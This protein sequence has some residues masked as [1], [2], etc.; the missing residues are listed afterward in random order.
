[1]ADHGVLFHQEGAVGDQDDAL[2][3]LLAQLV[4][5]DAPTPTAVAAAMPATVAA[6]L[7]ERSGID[8]LD[9]LNAEL[10]SELRMDFE[11]FARELW[12]PQGQGGESGNASRAY[13]SS[14]SRP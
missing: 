9:K 4:E 5:Q 13:S 7:S 12:T 3:A 2:N 8:D 1:M 10:S 11:K 6:G 14:S